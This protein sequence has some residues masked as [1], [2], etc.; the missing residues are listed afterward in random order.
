M[1]ELRCRFCEKP[2]ALMTRLAGDREF[3]SKE[4]RRNYQQRDNQLALERL[5]QAQTGPAQKASSGKGWPVSV[6][7][8][9]PPERLAPEPLVRENGSK[10]EPSLKPS[11]NGAP[12]KGAKGAAISRPDAEP[13]PSPARFILQDPAIPVFEALGQHEVEE[14]A[15][16][17]KVFSRLP[18]LQPPVTVPFV[19]PSSFLWHRTTQVAA[20]ANPDP[21]RFQFSLS[22]LPRIVSR[23]GYLEGQLRRTERIGFCPP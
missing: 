13:A 7:E 14:I 20:D 6:L 4:H 11:K 21:G 9:K 17:W 12:H 3:C 15:P 22:F 2:L 19:G 23:T 5:L 1:A 18:V 8:S 10:R 16:R